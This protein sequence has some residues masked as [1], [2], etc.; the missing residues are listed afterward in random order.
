MHLLYHH[1]DL[2]PFEAPGGNGWKPGGS[3]IPL[4]VLA[5]VQVYAANADPRFQGKGHSPFC[6]HTRER[7]IVA[8]DDL[9][10]VADLVSGKDFD[11][12]S[13]CSGYAIRR[14]TDAQLAHYRAAHRLHDI[15]QQLDPSRGGY[16]PDRPNRLAEQLRALE[17]W[18]PGGEDRYSEDS[19]RWRRMVRE[20]LARGHS[21]NLDNS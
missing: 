18:N 21:A 2:E 10:T 8:S 9:L 6:S 17:N 15:A 5:D 16:D 11:W 14:L 3:G 4:G 1:L 7:G 12:C 13:K 19:R 20:L